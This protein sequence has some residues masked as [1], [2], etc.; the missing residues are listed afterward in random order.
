[1]VFSAKF[2]VYAFLM[3]FGVALLSK[4]HILL[5]VYKIHLSVVYTFTTLLPVQSKNIKSIAIAI[6]SF[7]FFE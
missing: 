5:V 6:L 2:S 7:T 3:S 1:M 4:T